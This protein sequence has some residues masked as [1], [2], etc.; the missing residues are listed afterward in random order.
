MTEY[1]TILV[2]GFIGYTFCNEKSEGKILVRW[3]TLGQNLTKMGVCGLI[4]VSLG[5]W[6]NATFCR[7][8]HKCSML[9]V[10][11]PVSEHSCV[12]SRHQ[13]LCECVCVLSGHTMFPVV[14]RTWLSV[15]RRGIYVGFTVPE[16]TSCQSYDCSLKH[17]T[18][19]GHGHTGAKGCCRTQFTGAANGNQMYT[20]PLVE[21][22]Y[23][24]IPYIYSR[25]L[26][27][28]TRRMN[29]L[30]VPFCRF[31]LKWKWHK[32][33]FYTADKWMCLM[34]FFALQSTLYQPYITVWST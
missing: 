12:F 25:K 24:N 13:S 8:A 3:G 19:A 27:S 1:M 15:F 7:L 30:Q 4:C 6:K 2:M 16:S 21:F 31:Y 32:F 11:E 26:L 18:G 28:V 5:T 14:G 23:W 20:R 29:T 10:T 34:S 17:V 9:T 22:D 33:F